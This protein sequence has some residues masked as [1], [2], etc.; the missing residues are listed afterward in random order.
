MR[1]KKCVLKY[2]MHQSHKYYS[3][4]KLLLQQLST[5]LT[6][7]YSLSLKKNKTMPNFLQPKLSPDQFLKISTKKTPINSIVIINNYINTNLLHN[8]YQNSLTFKLTVNE[9]WLYYQEFKIFNMKNDFVLEGQR[10]HHLSRSTI[11]SDEI[12]Q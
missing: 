3:I 8:P 11:R 4:I 9:F 5:W 6:T 1:L 10:W 12:L 7:I 2:Y